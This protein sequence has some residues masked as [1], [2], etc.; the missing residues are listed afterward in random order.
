MK[1]W[2]IQYGLLSL[3]PPTFQDNIPHNIEPSSPASP[4][5]RIYSWIMRS[6]WNMI[7]NC[8]S[9]H[10]SCT[11]GL[12]AHI[13]LS[14]ADI[15]HNTKYISRIISS[16]SNPLDPTRIF[17]LSIRNQDNIKYILLCGCS[18]CKDHQLVGRFPLH[19]NTNDLS[20]LNIYFHSNPKFGIL[21]Q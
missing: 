5:A 20:I 19:Q 12:L 3:I 17:H 11:M 18:P 15:L 13:F 4:M 7:G 21:G 2:I 14:I 16:H 8:P 1:Y 9:H 6:Y 10:S